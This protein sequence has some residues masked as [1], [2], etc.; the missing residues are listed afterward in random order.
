MANQC[1]VIYICKFPY[2]TK[3]D[4]QCDFAVFDE[5]REDSYVCIYEEQ[6][7]STLVF[8]NNEKAYV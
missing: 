8:C 5:D 3:T 1:G 4:Q 7:N 6:G 2:R